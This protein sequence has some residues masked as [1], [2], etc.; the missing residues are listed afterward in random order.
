[1][2]AGAGT[3]PA[4]PVPQGRGGGP[5]WQAFNRWHYAAGLVLLPFFVL[6]SLTGI[7]YLYKPQVEPRLYGDLWR[8]PGGG[9]A[10]PVS[11]LEKAA[12]EALP[13]AKPLAY[14]DP[15]F[16]GASAQFTLLGREGRKWRVFVDPAKAQVLGHL[17]EDTMFMQV[18]K[19][20]H[21]SLLLGKPGAIVMDIVAGWGVVLVVCGLV[22]WWP[23]S[24]RG[25][26]KIR[27]RAAGRPFWR[28]LHA[29]PAAMGS[30]LILGFLLTGL[31]WTELTGQRLDALAKL[32]GSGGPP[33]GFAP[34]PF[35]VEAPAG[36]K[37][38]GLDSVVEVARRELPQDRPWIMY[39]KKPGLAWVVHHKAPRP[40]DRTYIHVD[41]YSGK[42]L[43]RYGW[44]DHGFIGKLTAMSVSLHEGTWFG[45]WN[46]LV[47]TVTALLVLAASLTGFWMW[48]K[49]RP[50]RGLGLPPYPPGWTW[51]WGLRLGVLVMG[52]AMP[53]F[54]ATVLAL[55]LLGRR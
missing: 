14:R 5:L 1:M 29:V 52:L 16:A 49:R 50:A 20:L 9:P 13:G 33:S 41:P 25:A 10:L 8:A 34:S 42:V 18:M 28:D 6:L 55:W 12:L 43:A 31:P 39:P 35:K 48:W 26:F 24:W 47:N 38:A 46:Y 32:T 3:P 2:R 44:K 7:A 21:G 22:V 27:W 45:A 37:A 30:V 4:P 17:A 54:G 19:D 53:G 51:P 36:A 11:A 40:Q 15:P 23:R